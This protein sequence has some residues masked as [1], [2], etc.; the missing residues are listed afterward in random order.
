[1]PIEASL[2][3]K[4]FSKHPNFVS[5]MTLA[6]FFGDANAVNDFGIEG[7]STSTR[8]TRSFPNGPQTW[9]LP[10]RSARQRR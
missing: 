4:Y 5:Q 9:V 1:M 7:H 10:M 8:S 2:I 6:I 3:L